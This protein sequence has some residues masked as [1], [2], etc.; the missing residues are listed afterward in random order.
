MFYVGSRY[1]DPQ[2]GRFINADDTDILDG[3]NDHMLENNLFAY[4][5]NNP[6]NMT[7]DGGYWPSWATKVLIGA[8]AI[9]LGAAIIAAT[10]GAGAAFIPAL[11]A[12]TQ[13]ALTSAAI[14]A[15]VGAGA[16][17]VSH[18]VSTG[19][20][21]GAGKAALTGAINGAADGFMTGGI[22]AGASQA[23]SGGFKVAANLGVKTGRNGGIQ[24]AKNVKVLSPNN[25]N[26]REAGGTLLKLGTKASNIRFD[27]GAKSLFHM[28][29][30]FGTNIHVPIGTIGSGLYGGIGQW[31]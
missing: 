12:G 5:F 19:S 15:A 25:V 14:G 20:W 16:S 28:N 4:C 6:V 21:K 9:V 3:G 29:A 2:I 7:D 27:V 17:T 31:K 22:M 13:A 24:L 11:V 10:G 26:F 8:G 30:Q 1:Y 23:L 18:R